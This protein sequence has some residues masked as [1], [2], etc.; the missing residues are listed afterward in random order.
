MCIDWSSFLPDMISSIFGSL[1]GFGLALLGER[2]VDNYKTRADAKEIKKLLIEELKAC[3]S[4]LQGLDA[5]SL[6][7]QPLKLSSWEGISHSNQLSLLDVNTRAVLFDVYN[8]MAELNSWS[9]V[10][11]KFYFEKGERNVLLVSEITS[12]RN[13]LLGED[14]TSAESMIDKAISCLS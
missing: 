9:Y 7:V 2:L 6:D 1:L 4:S 11:T 3:N 8:I 5:K 13:K 10:H 14:K 12:L